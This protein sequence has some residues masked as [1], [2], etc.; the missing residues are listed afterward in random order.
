MRN[1]KVEKDGANFLLPYTYVNLLRRD[2]LIFTQLF[3][4]MENTITASEHG[5]LARD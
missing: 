4:K 5:I 2:A 3:D 1:V